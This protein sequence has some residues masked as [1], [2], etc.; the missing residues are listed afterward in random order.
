MCPWRRRSPPMGSGL[1]PAGRDERVEGLRPHADP[2]AGIGD[3]LESAGV[4]LELQVGDR[5]GAR[6][7][8]DGDLDCAA[9]V[10]LGP[11]GR[12]LGQDRA[13]GLIRG[14]LP[15]RRQG[16]TEGLGLRV[17]GDRRH[18]DEVRDADLLDRRLAAAGCRVGR[19]RMRWP[20]A[21]R[22]PRSPRPR[23]SGWSCHGRRPAWRL[24]RSHPFP[25]C[26]PPLGSTAGQR[27]PSHRRPRH[28]RPAHTG[29]RR[30][31]V[32]PW[33]RRPWPR[34]PLR[35]PRLRPRRLPRRHPPRARGS[36]RAHRPSPPP[37]PSDREVRGRGPCA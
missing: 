9:L 3:R 17:R 1:R 19:R 18:P 21:A 31:W 13:L 16:E 25:W 11:D 32:V 22:W 23:P 8:G 35:P 24:D 28:R 5:H 12:V 15:G 10:D 6:S 29:S 2:K 37:R 7:R 4:V 26:R 20:P 33:P 34:R 30:G 36:H 14:D 27:S